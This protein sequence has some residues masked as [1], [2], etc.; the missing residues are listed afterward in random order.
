MLECHNCHYLPFAYGNIFKDVL[1][2]WHGSVIHCSALFSALRLPANLTNLLL[3]VRVSCFSS[4]SV[5]FTNT[6]LLYPSKV[7][8]KM[9]SPSPFFLFFTSVSAAPSCLKQTSKLFLMYQ[10]KIYWSYSPHNLN[11]SSYLSLGGT[12]CSDIW[13]RGSVKESDHSPQPPPPPLLSLLSFVKP[14]ELPGLLPSTNLEWKE[15]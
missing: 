11:I 8:A 3:P 12:L 14:H 1:G 15:A 7:L 10:E 9:T 13:L 6:N 5:L 4:S 2:A